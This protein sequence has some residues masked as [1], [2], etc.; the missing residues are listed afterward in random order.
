MKELD[1]LAVKENLPQVLAFI[2]KQLEEFN[3]KMKTIMLVDIAVEEIFINIASYAYEPETGSATI[4]TYLTEEPLTVVISFI[5]NG[6]PYDPLAKPDPNLN[7]PIQERKKGGLGIF[8]VKKTMD[9][10]S[11]EYKQG[12]NI[13]TIK[14]EIQ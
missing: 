2:D 1:I 3:C 11:Y 5:D 4:R 6:K 10:I 13:L 14:K 12:Q 9:T 7:L 8:M